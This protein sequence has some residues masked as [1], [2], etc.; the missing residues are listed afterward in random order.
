MNCEIPHRLG[1]R[2]EAY[3]LKGV[4]LVGFHIDRERNAAKTLASEEG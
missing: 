1:R 2:V 4:D 3:F